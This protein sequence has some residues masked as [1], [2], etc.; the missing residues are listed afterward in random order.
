MDCPRG[1]WHD[2][3]STGA[4]PRTS[5]R[6]IVICDWSPEN[7]LFVMSQTTTL[8][9]PE[10]SSSDEGENDTTPVLLQ[11]CPYSEEQDNQNVG[12]GLVAPNGKLSANAQEWGRW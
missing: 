5:A 4:A 11:L 9:D 2:V 6:G 3:G 8:Q 12:C 10:V 1:R 7:C